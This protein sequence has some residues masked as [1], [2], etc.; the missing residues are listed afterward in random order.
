MSLAIYR[1][2]FYMYLVTGGMYDSLG[3]IAIRKGITWVYGLLQVNHQLMLLLHCMEG[4][5]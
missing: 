1:F 3:R 4:L 2:G 5:F